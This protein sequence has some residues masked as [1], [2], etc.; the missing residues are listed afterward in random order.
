MAPPP[1]CATIWRP[2][3]LLASTRP[4]R[5]TRSTRSS[6]SAGISSTGACGKI[7]ALFT[8]MSNPPNLATHCS[9]M[10]WPASSS[11]TSSASV[12]TL[13]WAPA[14]RSAAHRSA[15]SSRSTSST[16]APPSTNRRAM[17]NPMPI[18]APVTIARRPSRLN[19]PQSVMS[20]AS[21]ACA[22][23][24]PASAFH[25][26]RGGPEGDP[27]APKDPGARGR[28]S[29]SAS[30]VERYRPGRE[31][32]RLE[33][34]RLED[35][36][37]EVLSMIALQCPKCELRFTSPNELT[38]HLR[39]DHRRLRGLV[40]PDRLDRS[41]DGARHRRTRVNAATWFRRVR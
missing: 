38:W 26:N 5:F 3:A 19:G 11:P 34:R 2:A 28:C 18:A 21:V 41:S 33:D 29:L 17:A 39:Q 9:T 15:A 37:L 27:V 24:A 14:S 40:L 20:L 12:S 23:R 32:R 4:R 13:P 1:P 22:G 31:D 16:S 7:P 8:R 6:S 35:R 30:A 10:R 36:R 25:P